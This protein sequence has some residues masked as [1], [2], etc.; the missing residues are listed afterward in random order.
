VDGVDLTKVVAGAEGERVGVE[1]FEVVFGAE[2]CEDRV[3]R[4]LDIDGRREAERVGARGGDVAE[5]AGPR[6]DVLKDVTMDCAKVWDVELAL[7]G[8]VS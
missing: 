2:G 6:E 7:Y 1:V 8:C 5:V 3:E 4:R